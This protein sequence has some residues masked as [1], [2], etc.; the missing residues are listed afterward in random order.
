MRNEFRTC[1][2]NSFCAS[3]LKMSFR[4]TTICTIVTCVAGKTPIL[5]SSLISV[6]TKNHGQF[7]MLKQ[8]YPF[9]RTTTDPSER[10]IASPYQTITQ[11]LAINDVLLFPK[12]KSEA[13]YCFYQSQYQVFQYQIRTAMLQSNNL[14]IPRPVNPLQMP[15]FPVVAINHISMRKNLSLSKKIMLSVKA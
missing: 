12:I 14:S 4:V 10:Q 9:H 6:E 7:L 1:I 15:V 8:M 2:G 5:C 13:S 3:T 11:A